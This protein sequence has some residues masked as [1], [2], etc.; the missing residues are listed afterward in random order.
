MALFFTVDHHI[1]RHRNWVEQLD[2]DMAM[3]SRTGIFSFLVMLFMLA[4]LLRDQLD[5]HLLLLN[6]VAVLLMVPL[7]LYWVWRFD[8]LHGRGATYWRDRFF[9]IT[10]ANIILWNLLGFWVLYKAEFNLALTLLLI[11]Q[12]AMAAGSA[13]LYAPFKQFGRIY[14]LLLLLPA[15]LCLLLVD[16]QSFVVVSLGLTLLMLYLQIEQNKISD[17]FWAQSNQIFQL[18]HQVGDKNS[19]AAREGFK[20]N[21]NHLLI[22]NMASMLDEPVKRLNHFL[23]P[24]KQLQANDDQRQSIK[25]AMRTC[26]S[27]GRMLADVQAYSALRNK[28]FF[29]DRSTQSLGRLADQVMDTCGP[30]AHEKDV[31]LSYLE[32]FDVPERVVA[33]GPHVITVLTNL[34]TLCIASSRPGE[35]SFKLSCLEKDNFHWLRWQMRTHLGSGQDLV[36]DLEEGYKMINESLPS[37]DL[38]LRNLPLAISLKLLKLMKGQITHRFRQ[39]DSFELLIMVPLEVASQ[40]QRQFNPERRL[41]GLSV[42]LLG[43]PVKGGKAL[44]AELQSWKI[45]A[46]CFQQLS[47]LEHEPANIIFANLPVSLNDDQASLYIQQLKDYCLTTQAQLM[48]YCSYPH[49]QS[50]KEDLAGLLVVPKPVSRAELHQVFLESLTRFES[51]NEQQ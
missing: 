15:A 2:R 6:M 40:Q 11:F 46:Q 23:E 22:A 17:V 28:Q 37:E 4:F 38:L 25:L 45:K 49:Q 13:M 24:L 39:D 51:N 14:L 32:N 33:D 26:D 43:M 27:I 34:L 3:R 35:L 48:I 29:I 21:I 12:T 36:N 20:Q 42:N 41:A 44:L 8:S 18:Q 10:L 19:K 5:N 9:I 31:E 1:T 16:Y 30:I 50:L 47:D 7:R